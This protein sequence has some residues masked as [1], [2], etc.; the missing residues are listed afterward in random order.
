MTRE[1]D[2]TRSLDHY[3]IGF[4]GP[5]EFE[6]FYPDE[7]MKLGVLTA[8]WSVAEEALC[9]VFSTILKDRPKAEAIFLFYHKSQSAS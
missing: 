7:I 5:Y 4:F 3:P 8:Y 9:S 1:K 2:I 6:T